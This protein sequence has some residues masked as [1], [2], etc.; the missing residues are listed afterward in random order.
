MLKNQGNKLKQLIPLT[1]LMLLWIAIFWDTL[2]SMVNMWMISDTFAHAFLILPIS[3]FLI[4]EK[5]YDFF[6]LE[7]HTNYLFVLILALLIIGWILGDLVS[8]NIVKQFM[9]ALMIPVIVA[10]LYGFQVLKTYLFPL[11]YLL[12]AVPFGDFLIPRLQE[13]TAYLSILGLQLTGI[14][15][16][17]EGL[18]ISIPTGDFEVAVACS[19]IRYLIA[20]VALGT[21]YAYITY[22]KTY[23]RLIFMVF[24]I[25]VP[26]L[27]N[28]IRAYGIMIIAH[29]SEMK[30]ATGFDHLIYGWLFFG[31]IIFLLFYIGH[32]WADEPI[33][34]KLS[35]STQIVVTNTQLNGQYKLALLI[36]V[37]FLIAPISNYYFSQQTGDL[38][39]TIDLTRFYSSNKVNNINTKWKPVF[40]G[41]E[42]EI[43]QKL[44]SNDQAIDFYLAY[45]PYPSKNKELVNSTNTSYDEKKHKLL[46]RNTQK[47]NIQDNIIYLDEYQLSMGTKRR[48]VWGWYYVFGQSI[49]KKIKIKILQAAGKLSGL[50]VDGSYIAIST[51]YDDIELARQQLTDF[52]EQNWLNIKQEI[53]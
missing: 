23:K 18:Y 42:I 22:Q 30:Y 35:T 52:L 21:L 51:Q 11:L 50:S 9:I 5:R 31:V 45:Y 40:H 19:G 24:A 39:K 37:A 44:K 32:R 49:N 2:A 41:N 7:K 38:N 1:V 47:I 27:A 29:Y 46:I 14:P 34:N 43:I 8:V 53:D 4:W 13:V 12:F 3:I 33:E 48:V 26:I 25:I 36:T 15:V 16:Y 6:A 20:S 17:W 10:A 28:G